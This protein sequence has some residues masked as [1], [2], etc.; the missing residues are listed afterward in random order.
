MGRLGKTM[1]FALT[2]IVG[3]LLLDPVLAQ[4]LETG[5]ATD[6][7]S[8]C[9][10]WNARPLQN[11]SAKYT[12]ACVDGFAQGRGVVEWSEAGRL[13]QRDEGEFV[14]GKLEVQPQ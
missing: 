14:N 6:S 5:W 9:K 2:A 13:V 8:G 10:V 4:T 11:G 1:A 12:G 7:R 3:W